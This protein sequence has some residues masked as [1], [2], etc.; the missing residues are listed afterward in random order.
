MSLGDRSKSGLGDRTITL[1]V[2]VDMQGNFL[3]YK[4]RAGLV[5]KIRKVT[6]HDVDQVLGIPP[7]MTHYPF[8]GPQE[9]PEHTTTFTEDEVT[10]LHILNRLMDAQI[11]RR[12]ANGHAL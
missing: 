9:P 4:A 10:D 7:R 8:G 12:L 5:H 1:S 3:D 11:K 6:Y 2:K